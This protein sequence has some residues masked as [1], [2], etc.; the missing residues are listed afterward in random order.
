MD[1]LNMILDQGNGSIVRQLAGNFGL[2]EDQT[3]SAITNLLPALGQGLARNAS[4]SGG[5]DALMGALTSG[6]HQRYLED[7]STLGMEETVQDGNG[8]LGHILGSKEV[9]RQVA[10]QAAANTG[11]GADILKKMLPVIAAMAMG[12]L[13]RQTT[14]SREAAAAGP[15]AGGLTD[16]L[17]Q[18]LDANRGGSMLDNVIGMAS[19]IFQK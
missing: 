5:L 15:A 12:A 14:G 6:G 19:R 3:V 9:S 18:F 4:T 13:S 8:I 11:V 17:S 2:N 7:P 16:L 1:L 10:Q